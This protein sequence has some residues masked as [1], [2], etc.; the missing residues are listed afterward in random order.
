MVTRARKSPPKSECE[1]AIRL[2][3]HDWRREAGLR[4][5]PAIELSFSAFKRWAETKGYGHYFDFR[6]VMGPH[7]D[8]E[9]W[10]DDEFKLNWTR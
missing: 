2:L 9:R 3:C 10:F 6:S 7:E 5:V 1:K 8:A 4:D